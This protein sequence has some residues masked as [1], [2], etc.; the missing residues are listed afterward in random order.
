MLAVRLVANRAEQAKVERKLQN[1]TNPTRIAELQARLKRLK[2]RE[3]EFI[4][5]LGTTRP[6][7]RSCWRE[8]KSLVAQE[9]GAQAAEADTRALPS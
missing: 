9:G 7:R 5:Q 3:Q 2:Q 6:K 1:A 8:A 4:A